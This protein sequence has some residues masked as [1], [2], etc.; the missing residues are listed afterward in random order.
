[1]ATGETTKFHSPRFQG[2]T[3]LDFITHMIAGVLA[4]II[5]SYVQIRYW[6]F[7]NVQ[8]LQNEDSIEVS[9]LKHELK[10][11]KN[12]DRSMSAISKFDDISRSV[13]HSRVILLNQALQRELE[14][15]HNLG[16]VP[17]AKNIS[18]YVLQNK[19]SLTAAENADKIEHE[20]LA[21]RLEEMVNFEN[22]QQFFNEHFN[23]FAVSHQKQASLDTMWCCF[24]RCGMPFLSARST[25]F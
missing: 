20:D 15:S 6:T 11:W 9:Q 23:L 24:L 2:V 13:I 10:M 21:R 8:K 7:R 17:L 25:V 4:L 22:K 1:M 3:F 16:N 12:T 19:D 18:F 5:L 14:S